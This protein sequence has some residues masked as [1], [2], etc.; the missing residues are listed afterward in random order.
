M[1]SEKNG[2]DMNSNDENKRRRIEIISQ[3]HKRKNL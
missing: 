2:E 1:M 3:K